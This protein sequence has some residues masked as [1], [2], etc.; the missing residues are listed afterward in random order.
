MPKYTIRTHPTA[1]DLKGLRYAI[2]FPRVETLEL[3]D[4]N[5]FSFRAWAF[6][7]DS[8]P[9]SFVFSFDEKTAIT[10]NTLRP[11][12][13]S[14]YNV[15][16]SLCG[17]HVV[18]P[19]FT[20]FEFGVICEGST[21]WLA[22]I[23][24]T[25]LQVLEGH[26]EYLF[27]DN[28]DNRSVD[29][30]S[31][32]V[33]IDSENLAAWSQYFDDVGARLASTATK[34]AFCLAPAKEF[35]FPDLYPVRRVGMTPQDQFVSAFSERAKLINPM[36]L[37]YAQRNL[38][39]SKNDTHWT[40]FGAS[41]VAEEICNR[42]EIDFQSP[43]FG[44]QIHN[45][46]G[47]LGIKFNP[48]RTEYCFFA[49]VSCLSSLTY[50]NCIPVRG[51]IISI[52]NPMASRNETCLIFGSSSSESIAKQL[53]NTF[54]RVVRV[55]SG[56]EIDFDIIEH[57]KPSCVLVIFASRFLVRAPSKDFNIVIEILRKLEAMSREQQSQLRSALSSAP[58]NKVDNYYATILS[59]LLDKIY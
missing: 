27:L 38:T 55:F 57:E 29:Q 33:T 13:K 52:S 44:Y 36:E 25:R 40:D 41:L 17:L 9:L 1:A 10:P 15:A 8:K 37:L 50:D 34:F 18:I 20:N 30:Y 6:S 54:T 39:F 14:V 11:D 26:D 53:T 16:P 21:I 47:D 49:D 59:S 51:N 56:A 22:Q 28:D 12:V 31:G 5:F 3:A 48:Q 24:L 35:I 58:V 2:D 23:E 42:L 43:D 32:K 7:A 46:T 45:F 4:D 19:V